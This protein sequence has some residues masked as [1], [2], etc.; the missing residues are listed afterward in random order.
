[1]KVLDLFSGIGGFSLGLE[2]AGMETIA[3]CEIDP[4]CRKVLKKHWPEVPIHEDIKELDGEQY[5]GTVDV[6]CGGFPC[7]PFSSAGD[8]RGAEHDSYLWPEMF[9][10]ICEVQPAWVVGENVAGITNMELDEVLSNLESEGYACQAFDIPAAGVDARHIRHRIWILGY[11][12][13]KGESIKPVNDETSG[14]Q[15]IFADPD[16]KQVERLTESWR[17]C[18]Y[19][20]DEPAIC[21]AD[22]GIP[23]RMDRLRALGNAVVPQIPEILG[24]AIMEAA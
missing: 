22:D 13:D 19:G 9:R 16:C 6:V 1:M 4:F 12:Y 15:S 24:K 21:G 17:E 5:R 18:F 14:M 23:N 10:V 2:R 8:Q 3:F 20:A 7:Q 11:A